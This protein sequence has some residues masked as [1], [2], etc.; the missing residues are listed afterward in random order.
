MKGLTSMEN[1][2]VVVE[3]LHAQSNV[4][5]AQVDRHLQDK[6]TARSAV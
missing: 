2:E 3:V 6:D 5:K 1:V 4:Q